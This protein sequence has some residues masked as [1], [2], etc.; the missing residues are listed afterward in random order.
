LSKPYHYRMFRKH[1]YRKLAVAAL[2]VLIVGLATACSSWTGT[3]TVAEKEYRA[4]ST[5]VV[6][7]GKV[8][9][10]VHTPECFELEIDADN[11]EE[12]ELCV[13]REVWDRF[14]AGDRITVTEE[15]ANG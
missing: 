12:H 13:D 1:Y 4:A 10:T 7:S 14:D 8:P 9:V 15:G 3:G 11:G 6:M 2:L 5:I